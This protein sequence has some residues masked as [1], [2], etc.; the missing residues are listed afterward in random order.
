VLSAP[1]PAKGAPQN[2]LALVDP[3]CRRRPGW[4]L[5]ACTHQER[6]HQSV[7]SPV[8]VVVV[9]GG[10]GVSTCRK[11]CQLQRSR[12]FCCKQRMQTVNCYE[13]LLPKLCCWRQDSNPAPLRCRMIPPHSCRSAGV[14]FLEGLSHM[15][16][17]SVDVRYHPVLALLDC[18]SSIL[19]P[20]A[21]VNQASRKASPP[22][23]SPSPP[24]CTPGMRWSTC[25]LGCPC[26]AAAS[27]PAAWCTSQCASAEGRVWV[28]EVGAREVAACVLRSPHA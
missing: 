18:C 11:A 8:V 13:R 26:S 3:P 7:Q 10:G 4:S 15:Q 21:P 12:A 20:T 14:V 25:P 6:R 27:C 28:G 1:L 24:R 2:H 9:V 17:C 23:Q 16:I 5:P 19:T 22:A